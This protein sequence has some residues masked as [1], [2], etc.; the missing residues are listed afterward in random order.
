MVWG[1]FVI[2]ASIS[3]IAVGGATSSLNEMHRQLVE[4]RG[5]LDDRT[6]GQLFALAQA[7]PG[8]NVLAVSLFGYWIAGFAGM[9]AATFGMLLP[10]GTLAFFIG[11]VAQRLKGHPALKAINGGLVP[12]AVG[13]IMA[14]GVTIAETAMAHGWGWIVMTVASA[15]FVWRTNYSPLWMLACG[16][17]IGLIIG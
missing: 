16:A 8:P 5:W 14:G 15:V 17:V 2:F 4:N 12:L 10:A 9:M 6:F 7:A 3:L 1:L 13:L 11:G